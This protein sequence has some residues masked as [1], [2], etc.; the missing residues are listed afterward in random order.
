MHETSPGEVRSG[1]FIPQS[2]DKL[3]LYFASS[4][5]LQLQ[6]GLSGRP[7]LLGNGARN[8]RVLYSATSVSCYY[9]YE[10]R[11]SRQA[12]R[13]LF[14]QSAARRKIQ[15]GTVPLRCVAQLGTRRAMLRRLP[16]EADL[17]GWDWKA[18][19]NYCSEQKNRNHGSGRG[20]FRPVLLLGCH[21]W[22]W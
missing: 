11:V 14:G 1:C 19:E 5:F 15:Y 17:Q 13:R 8:P 20:S 2:R 9:Q 21:V 3:L 6:Y 18:D 10:R 7:F 12:K 22:S 16:P 4:S